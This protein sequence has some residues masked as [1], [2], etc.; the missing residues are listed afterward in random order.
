MDDDSDVGRRL[1]QD[2]DQG[3][4][5]ERED[6]FQYKDRQLDEYTLPLSGVSSESVG[7]SQ[8][9]ASY[10]SMQS[11]VSPSPTRPH[12]PRQLSVNFADADPSY[13]PRGVPPEL[14]FALSQ[15][16]GASV[17]V[18]SR[19]SEHNSGHMSA[20]SAS[21]SSVPS[22]RA[23]KA[24][25]RPTFRPS[26]LREN[27][28]MQLGFDGRISEMAISGVKSSDTVQTT[29][30]MSQESVHSH[31][32]N[33]LGNSIN[34]FGS[35]GSEVDEGGDNFSADDGSY[36]SDAI[37]P[38][39]LCNV[40]FPLWLSRLLRKPPSLSRI[41]AFIVRTA[42]CFWFC[43]N[44]VQGSSTDRAVLTRL[45]ILCAFFC[46]FQVGA[47]MYLATIL[48]IVDDQRGVLIGFAP[49]FWNLNGAGLSVG[50][51]GFSLMFTCFFTIKV[52][53]RVDLVKAIRYLWVLLWIVPFEIFFNISLFDYHRVTE[54]WIKHWYVNSCLGWVVAERIFS[55]LTLYFSFAS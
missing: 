21:V 48:L 7:G 3:R 6:E 51:L 33:S 52:I 2:R 18:M 54:V 44:R 31:S 28:A 47:S 16:S 15:G 8:A 26:A 22:P 14:P 32:G 36:G 30:A 49:N 11:P 50:V 12:P 42:P 17:S 1:F 13:E 43:G 37:E 38:I 45:N 25:G 24:P 40:K 19:D 39:I 46:F 53:Q 5:Q 20:S 29:S 9:S 34:E 41:A 35:Q 27:S 4:N 55:F 23:S 10:A